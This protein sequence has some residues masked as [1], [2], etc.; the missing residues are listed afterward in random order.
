MTYFNKKEEVL[1]IELTQYGKHLLSIGKLN[2]TYY[3]FFDDDI[4]YDGAAAGLSEIQNEIDPRITKNTPHKKTQHSHVGLETQLNTDYNK[5]QKPYTIAEHEKVNM[6]PT[7]EREYVL[8]NPLGNSEMGDQTPPRFNMALFRGKIEDF[9]KVLSSEYQDLSIP[10]V[11]INLTQKLQVRNL[12][13]D[14]IGDT[15]EELASPIFDDDTFIGAYP[16]YLLGIFTESGVPFQKENFDIEVYEIIDASGSSGTKLENELRQLSF[17]TIPNPAIVN[18]I[19][20]D[21]SEIRKDIFEI[22]PNHVE[23]FFDILTD[24]EISEGIICS[25]A[26]R[27]KSLNMSVDVGINCPDLPFTDAILDPYF[28]EIDLQKSTIC[29]DEG[30]NQ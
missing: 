12:S 9:S 17:A 26:S 21:S 27:I 6:P 20:L 1:D 2:P 19:L 28:S 11:E 29:K 13:T 7:T 3:R 23:Y 22:T 15:D 10:Q 24:E 18:G 16:D 30:G 8:N 4:L 14:G 25:N 5:K